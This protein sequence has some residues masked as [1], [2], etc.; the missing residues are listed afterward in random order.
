VGDAAFESRPQLCSS[1]RIGTGGETRGFFGVK[2]DVAR[3]QLP[4][5]FAI[6]DQL[7]G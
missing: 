3:Q 2:V 1:N 6:E 5:L 7:S 4:E